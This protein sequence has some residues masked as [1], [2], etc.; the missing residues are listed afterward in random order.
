LAKTSYTLGEGSTVYMETATGLNT[1]PSNLNII[2]YLCSTSAFHASPHAKDAI[3]YRRQCTDVRVKRGFLR[4]PDEGALSRERE[5]LIGHRWMHMTP[6]RLIGNSQT[7]GM[8]TT[9]R[10][11]F[12]FTGTQ[13]SPS[14]APCSFRIPFSL[15]VI[16]VEG[17]AMADR[18][19]PNLSRLPCGT[20]FPQNARAYRATWFRAPSKLNPSTRDCSRIPSQPMCSQP[21]SPVTRLCDL[22]AFPRL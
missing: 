19:P 15:E 1:I 12:V 9:A 6:R 14:T 7:P 2:S 22:L 13:S 18:R 20:E 3:E 16:R 11:L 17:N 4:G 5:G 8:H 21:P 10:R